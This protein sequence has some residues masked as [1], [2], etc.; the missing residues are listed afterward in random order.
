VKVAIVTPAPR[1]LEGGNRVTAERWAALLRELGHD[2]A[3][4][5]AGEGLPHDGDLLLALHAAKSAE[6]VERW[7]EE[8]PAAPAVLLL[9]GTDFH[10][11]EAQKRR[12]FEALAKVERIALLQPRQLALLPPELRAKAR[13]VRQSALPPASSSARPE[14][15]DGSFDVSVVGHLREVKDPLRA[16]LAARLLPARSK[17]RILHA[18]EA[19]SPEMQL[20]A[21]REQAGN[22]RYRWLG[23]LGHDE[24]R[25]L[26]AGTKLH[27]LTSR[28]EGGANVVSEALA[29]GVP[30]ISSRIDGSLGIL[31]DAY[32]GYFEPGDERELARLLERAE[33]DA[34][35]LAALTRWCRNLAP[36]VAPEREREALGRL[37]DEIAPARAIATTTGGGTSHGTGR[38]GGRLRELGGEVELPFTRLAA[39]VKRGLTRERG[40]QLDCCWFYDEEG[41]RLF[42][43]ICAT[44]EYYVTR[45]EDEILSAHASEI[46]A[47]VEPSTTVVEL[48]SG[49]ATKTRRLLEAL[50]ARPGPASRRLH[51]VSIDISP[52]ALAASARDL[53]ARYPAL[54]VTSICADYDDGVAR[55]RDVTGPPR[56]VLWLGS[57]V[58]NFHR[59][60]AAAF[61]GRVR[62]QLDPGDRFLLGVDL[63]KDRRVLERAYADAAGVT[64][65]FNRNLL[66][67]VNREL[68]GDFDLGAFRHR[69][70]WDEEKGRI[71]MWL[72]SAKAQR[73]RI[74]L[75]DLDVAFAA[76][77][78]IHTED[79]YKY[80]LAE[81]D[82]LAEAAGFAADARWLDGGER[83]ADA[84]W[85]PAEPAG[86]GRRGAAP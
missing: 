80:S 56:L 15:G 66:A 61:L 58:G 4:A 25:A 50:L 65:R 31:G 49:S 5:G 7:K 83:F 82:A 73:A 27:V 40:K 23:P 78:A 18:G 24:A 64:A 77:E 79:S 6:A 45:A 34:E 76:G 70:T 42:E 47:R 84:L 38:G 55:L 21:E 32:P 28:S 43:E 68:G 69:A 8:R 30:V 13:V 67:R 53:L 59:P 60:D 29:A 16:A 33:S 86:I 41:S 12:A 36:L 14:R 22:P 19:L 35:F 74:A 9:A 3:I 17:L 81:I 37:I 2:V 11:D 20:A 72:V 52:S 1:G 46:A 10:G 44:P 39:S 71:E 26:I 48:G 75:L 62:A 51:Y 57:N 85:R 63:R 54:E